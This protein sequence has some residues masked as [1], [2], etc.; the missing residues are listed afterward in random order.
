MIRVC[1]YT[2]VEVAEEQGKQEGK[3]GGEHVIGFT[4]KK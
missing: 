1:Q 2:G 3:E 4:V